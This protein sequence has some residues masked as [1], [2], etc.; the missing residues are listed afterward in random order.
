[1]ATNPH[2]GGALPFKIPA[3]L[4]HIHAIDAE[5]HRLHATWRAQEDAFEAYPGYPDEDPVAEAMLDQATATRDAMFAAPVATATALALKMEAV[6]EGGADS[7]IHMEIAPGL[8]VLDAIERDL[9][10]IAQREVEGW[11]PS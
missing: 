9:H 10:R 8:T 4:P 2:S 6:R 1:M 7:I 3:G 11:K 5:F